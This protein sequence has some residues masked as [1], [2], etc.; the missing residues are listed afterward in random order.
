V[1]ISVSAGARVFDGVREHVQHSQPET[2]QVSFTLSEYVP[3]FELLAASTTTMYQPSWVAVY[4][5][6]VLDLF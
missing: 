6:V 5:C 2:L 1:E 3:L 4:D